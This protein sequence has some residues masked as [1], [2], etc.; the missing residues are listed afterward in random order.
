[1]IDHAFEN[2]IKGFYVFKLPQGGKGK[3]EG[4]FWYNCKLISTAYTIFLKYI[5]PKI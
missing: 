1:M 5:H 2:D 3:G 4:N